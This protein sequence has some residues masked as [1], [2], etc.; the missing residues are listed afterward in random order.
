MVAVRDWRML[1]G[2]ERTS[3][4]TKWLVVVSVLATAMILT[5]IGSTLYREFVGLP[6]AVVV[7][8]GDEPVTT[9]EYRAFLAYRGYELKQQVI[10]L[11][12]GE[13]PDDYGNRLAELRAQLASLAFQAATDLAHMTLI[14]AE[15][16]TR[17]LEIA[18]ADVK[19]AL[20]G[21]FGVG[22]DERPSWDEVL[23]EVVTATGLG[24]DEIEQFTADA[25]RRERLIEELFAGTDRSPSHLR[26]LEIVL[27]SEGDGTA[28]LDRLQNGEPMEVIA[29]E[30]SVD[31]ASRESGGQVNWTP[32]GIRPEAWDR[33]VFDA[34]VGH[35][36]GPFEADSRWYLFRVLDRVDERELS[37]EH[38][39][40]L[41]QSKFD[42]WIAERT[43]TQPI[44]YTLS[45]DVI[46]WTERNPIR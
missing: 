31:P 11:D 14:R 21:I 20:V 29:R 9:L 5:L 36:V 17:G 4:A 16:I 45:A 43:E 28:A 10:A 41:R 44:S 19:D 15:W 12:E 35:V 24:V 37:G 46:D 42:D 8:V 3:A 2:P 7:T 22:E 32:P 1:S 33:A 25:I 6:N 18:E 34:L 23:R 38:E 26:G 40:R 30:L 27:Q 13:Q 39:E